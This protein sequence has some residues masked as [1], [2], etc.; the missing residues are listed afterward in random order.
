MNDI[1]F[2]TT[3]RMGQPGL[4]RAP[5]ALLMALACLLLASG[6]VSPA[7]S[8]M[9]KRHAP[10]A[11]GV[12]RITRHPVSAAFFLIG[13]AHLL[14]ADRAADLA[15]FGGFCLFAVLATAHQ[16]LRKSASVEGY[17]AFRQQT[18]FL[19]FAAVL[20]RKQP[21]GAALREWPWPAFAL[22]AGLFVALYLFHGQLFGAAL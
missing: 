6:V 5:A 22:G 2:Y 8:S 9:L 19:P 21:L 11:M 3:D 15:F 16:D 14:V 10:R 20:Q 18:S 4:A 7:P 1:L 12:M 13:L 17:S